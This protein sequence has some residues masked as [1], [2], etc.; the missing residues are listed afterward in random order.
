MG[1]CGEVVAG[2]VGF[3][4]G[5]LGGRG[6]TPCFFAASLAQYL[7]KGEVSCVFLVLPNSLPKPPP[8]GKIPPEYVPF[9]SQ[10]IF[11]IEFY[12]RPQIR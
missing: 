6:F 1:T 9:I 5:G 4:L 7:R 11:S 3:G 10:N 2:L 12:A 8:P